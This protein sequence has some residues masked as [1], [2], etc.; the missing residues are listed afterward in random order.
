MVVMSSAQVNE[1]EVAITIAYIKQSTDA[2]MT[3][4]S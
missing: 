1:P 4:N 2:Y 3:A